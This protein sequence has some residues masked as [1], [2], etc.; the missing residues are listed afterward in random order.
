MTL[1]PPAS[2]SPRSPRPLAAGRQPVTRAGGAPAQT[3]YGRP[4]A[5]I[6]FQADDPYTP[7]KATLGKMLSCDPR[8]S[9]GRGPTPG[10]GADGAA[11][12]RGRRLDGAATSRRPRPRARRRRS[13]RTRGRGALRGGDRPRPPPRSG[14]Y[15]T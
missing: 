14:G 8:L 5:P 10:R 7:E 3:A 9:G 1:A 12:P 11:P 4:D 6:P 13:A 15:F 2:S